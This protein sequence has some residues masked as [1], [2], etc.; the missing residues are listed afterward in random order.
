MFALSKVPVILSDFSQPWIFSKF[1]TSSQIS[2]VY[3]IRPMGEEFFDA[4]VRIDGQPWRTN[5]Q[6]L[7]IC[8]ASN[9]VRSV[10]SLYHS[11]GTYLRSS[12]SWR[13]WVQMK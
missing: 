1:L 9:I 5:I 2:N 11:K 8:E 3:K 7:E 4:D 13:Q 10:I 12:V 6:F